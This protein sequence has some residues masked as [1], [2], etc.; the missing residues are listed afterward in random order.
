MV[1]PR[2]PDPSYNPE[3]SALEDQLEWYS[4]A[5]R[6]SSAGQPPG[7]RRPGAFTSRLP[8]SHARDQAY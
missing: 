3:L 5:L 8:R 4:V 2:I 1:T 7:P 6:L